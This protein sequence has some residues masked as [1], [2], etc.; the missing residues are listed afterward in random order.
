MPLRKR[1][2]SIVLLMN[3]GLYLIQPWVPYIEYS[4]RKDAIAKNLCINR[5]NPDSECNGK[6]YLKKQVARMTETPDAEK[7]NDKK[8]TP[9]PSKEFSVC[10][11]SFYITENVLLI[12]KLNSNPSEPCGFVSKVFVPPKA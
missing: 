1:I 7:Q 3:I 6:C 2:Y 12:S 5:F 10:F 9:K 8:E 11:Y 4:L